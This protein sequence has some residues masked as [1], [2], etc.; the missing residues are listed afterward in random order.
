MKC[1]NVMCANNSHGVCCSYITSHE[2]HSKW[3]RRC[4]YRNYFLSREALVEWGEKEIK[5]QMAREKAYAKGWLRQYEYR[6][7]YHSKLSIREE[8]RNFVDAMARYA[9]LEFMLERAK[10]V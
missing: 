10:H 9:N 7:S 8:W 6:G 2:S 3:V 5:R 4:P 1:E